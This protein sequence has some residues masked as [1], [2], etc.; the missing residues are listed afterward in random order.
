MN[1]PINTFQNI[2]ILPHT[3]ICVEILFK[4]LSTLNNT[5][6]SLVKRDYVGNVEMKPI[7][8]FP[9]IR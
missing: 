2:C 6:V 9:R 5:A 7:I 1:K 3:I 4:G 8:Y